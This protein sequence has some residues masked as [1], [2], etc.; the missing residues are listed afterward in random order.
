VDILPT[1]MDELDIN[2][3]LM[4]GYNR[5]ALGEMFAGSLV[6]LVLRINRSPVFLCR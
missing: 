6:N 1:V 5:S 3:L 2:L 4:G